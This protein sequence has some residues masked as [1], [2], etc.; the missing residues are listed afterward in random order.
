MMKIMI[1]LGTLLSA[2]VGMAAS[3]QFDF[4]SLDGSYTGIDSPAHSLGL[5]G[6]A[7]DKWNTIGHS[8]GQPDETEATGNQSL[9]F[10]NTTGGALSGI[11][12]DFGAFFQVGGAGPGNPVG[13]I[14]WNNFE[15]FVA[16][17]STAAIQ[18]R[19]QTALG[20]DLFFNGFNESGGG[21][22]AVRVSGLAAGTYD[23][24]ALAFVD[25]VAS[26]AKDRVYNIRMG[27]NMD[28]LVDD[29]P[30]VVGPVSATS[31]WTAGGDFARSQLTISGPTDWITIF[32]TNPSS[33]PAALNGI[34]IVAVPEPMMLG[35]F[36]PMMLCRRRR[37]I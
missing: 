3:I 10:V 29:L 9:S 21:V 20:K 26:S 12:I 11:K 19:H 30:E 17:Y 32:S 6:A 23:V 34:Q 25:E 24:I 5:L 1:A 33:A 27:V 13:T 15:T 31:A 4:S 36:L 14:T 37:L 18:T 8:T 35:L 16:D 28:E 7:D 2:S 22:V